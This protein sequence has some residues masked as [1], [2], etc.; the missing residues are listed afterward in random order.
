MQ[1]WSGFVAQN[2]T[3][4]SGCVVSTKGGPKERALKC[5]EQLLSPEL[6]PGVGVRLSKRN[7]VSEPEGC[8]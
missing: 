8:F 6:G 3:V 1:K 5:A 4:R 7:P 2:S